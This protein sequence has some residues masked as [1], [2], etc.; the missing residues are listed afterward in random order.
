MNKVINSIDAFLTSSLEGITAMS[1]VEL[2]ATFGTEVNGKFTHAIPKS[3]FQDICFCLSVVEKYKCHSDW[4]IVYD[5]DLGLR[6]RMRVSM[7]NGTRAVN[8]IQKTPLDKI[9]L[10]YSRRAGADLSVN[11]VRINAKLEIEA[12]NKTSVMQ[13]KSVRIS[14][15][16]YYTFKSSN[17]ASIVWKFE[18]IQ[19]WT[20]LTVSEAE[21][22]MREKEPVYC[23]ECEVINLT[24]ECVLTRQKRVVLGCALLMKMEDF[25]TFPILIKNASSPLKD[26]KTPSLVGEFDLLQADAL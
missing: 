6:R 25:F 12:K 5:Y 24:S 9:D 2:E 7:E 15:R 14:L 4:F 20:G 3:F 23:F 19:Y 10:R 21:K 1:E 22:N 16:M 17:F 26:R 8:V 18:V 11:A 13:F